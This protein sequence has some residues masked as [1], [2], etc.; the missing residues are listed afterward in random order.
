[1]NDCTG[2]LY[3]KPDALDAIELATHFC[4]RLHWKNST[5]KE[6]FNAAWEGLVH[7]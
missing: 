1:V 3:C 6:E 4:E 5:A 7:L 2:K